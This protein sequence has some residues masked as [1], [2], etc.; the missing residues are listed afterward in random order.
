MADNTT[1][2]PIV[3][4]VVGAGGTLLG[5]AIG[6]ISQ[7]VQNKRVLDYNR[8]EAEKQRAWNEKMYNEQNAWN[9]EMWNKTN[10]YNSPQ[11]QVNRLRDAGLNPLFYGLDGSSANAMSSAQPLGYERAQ[12]E[13]QPNPFGNTARD[14]ASATGLGLQGMSLK[15]DI[16]LKNAQIDKLKADETGV[17][18]DN[19][20]K[21]KT[22]ATRVESE[23]LA[24]SLTKE[25]INEA[26][27][28]IN[29]NE[30]D[31]KESIARTDNE[32]E[33]KGLI[34][35]EKALTEAKAKEILEMLPYQKNLA[36][37]Q[38]LAQKAAASAS[39][40]HAAIQKGLFEA[41]YVE[42]TIED[43]EKSIQQKGKNIEDIDTGIK[44]KESQLDINELNKVMLEFKMAVRNGTVF[45]YSDD[46]GLSRAAQWYLDKLVKT[47]STASEAVG[48]GISGLLK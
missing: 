36:E 37:A 32:V 47:L 34:L 42:K 6:S 1:F 25:Q 9:L 28:R 16:E 2:N 38:T 5:S 11:Q 4:S 45:D 48:A 40:A 27:S 46:K 24:N 13:N 15:K 29:K 43:L 41:G 17:R 19:D 3:P 14:M 10:E 44:L 20:F 35:A 22:L 30:Q 23:Q 21:E 31:I 33:K 12:A 7:A 8:E 18:L 39:W 26:K